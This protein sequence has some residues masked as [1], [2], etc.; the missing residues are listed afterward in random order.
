[1][2]IFKTKL[3]TFGF[4][5]DVE[6]EMSQARTALAQSLA[7]TGCHIDLTNQ[8]QNFACQGLERL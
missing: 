6:G 3:E 4:V 5:R 7:V 8:R 2:R 1:M